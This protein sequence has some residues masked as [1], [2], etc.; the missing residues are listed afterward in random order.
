M[1]FGIVSLLFPMVRTSEP[2]DTPTHV[3]GKHIEWRG[4]SDIKGSCFASGQGGHQELSGGEGG[5]V[6]VVRGN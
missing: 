6:T 3:K 1:A 5:G 2:A 4:H